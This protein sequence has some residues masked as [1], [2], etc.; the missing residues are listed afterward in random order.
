MTKKSGQGLVELIISLFV[1]MPLI[2]IMLSAFYLIYAKE[3]TSYIHYRALLCT[4]E[5]DKS[6]LSCTDSA[7]LKINKFLFFHKQIKTHIAAHSNEVQITTEGLHFKLKTHYQKK[8][9]IKIL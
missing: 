6:I 7:S 3:V 8:L 1:L 5:L 4:Q 9:Q 2:S